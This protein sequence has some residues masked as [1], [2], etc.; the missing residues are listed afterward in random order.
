MN[1]GQFRGQVARFVVEK[2]DIVSDALVHYPMIVSNEHLGLR[3]E[4]RLERKH[5]Y[6]IC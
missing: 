4:L 2:R 6:C 5:M 3:L 1:C